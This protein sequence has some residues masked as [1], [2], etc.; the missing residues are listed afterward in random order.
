VKKPDPEDVLDPWEVVDCDCSRSC[1]KCDGFGWYYR[2][3]ETG[4]RVSELM[5]DAMERHG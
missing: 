1:E 4:A 2:N 5:R 3:T